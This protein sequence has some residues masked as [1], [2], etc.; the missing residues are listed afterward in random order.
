MK[1][2]KQTN[3]CCV[4]RETLETNIKLWLIDDGKGEFTGSSRIGFLDHMLKTFC[5][6]STL[7]LSLEQFEADLHVDMH[8]GVEDLALVLGTAFR[9]LLDYSRAKRFGYAIVPMD[10]ALTMCSIDLSGRS[11]LN[12]QASFETQSIGDFPVELIEEFFRS[13]SSNARITLHIVKLFG[14][15]SHHIAESMFKAF[16]I[17]V[18]SAIEK[19]E[20]TQ[21]TKGVID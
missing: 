3:R 17:A 4:E 7:S 8:H 2:E 9:E 15:N 12:F 11:F 10:E 5:R 19:I 16:A 21:S 14:R 13:F 6:F 20:S 1:I 18:R